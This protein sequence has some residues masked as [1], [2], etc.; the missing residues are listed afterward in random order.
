M[1]AAIPD[2]NET[3][4]ERKRREGDVN[5]ILRKVKKIE[6]EQLRKD[7]ENDDEEGLDAIFK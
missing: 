2:K 5:R 3:S 1:A 4:E 7:M 6:E